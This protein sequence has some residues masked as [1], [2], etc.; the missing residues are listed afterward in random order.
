MELW[1]LYD[2][3][4]KPLGRTVMRG[5]K[6]EEGEYH[7]I[8][9]VL[10]VNN[11]GKILITKRHPY[12]NY[13]GMWEITGGAAIK[14]ETS[15]QAAARELFEE[16]GLKAAPDE[17]S[18]SSTLIRTRTRSIVDCFLYNGNFSENDIILQPGETVDYKLVSPYQLKQMAEKRQ[19]IYYTYLRIKTMFPD[20]WDQY[21]ADNSHI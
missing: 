11:E 20:F 12:K 18:Y 1:D 17:L 14:G 3:N 10:S 2:K 4:R 13:G 16:T 19:F 5:E 9:N 21:A 7:V 6:L 15:A 8:V